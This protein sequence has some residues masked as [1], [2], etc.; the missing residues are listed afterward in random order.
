M[1]FGVFVFFLAGAGSAEGVKA[2]EPPEFVLTALSS[3]FFWVVNPFLIPGP[4]LFVVA[5]PNMFPH[6]VG[7]EERE[8]P[9]PRPAPREAA[10]GEVCRRQGSD[11][12]PEGVRR[13]DKSGPGSMR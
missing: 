1:R 9:R 12:D 2:F 10:H 11:G 13:A 7:A 3:L 8:H 6:P 4:L 5:P